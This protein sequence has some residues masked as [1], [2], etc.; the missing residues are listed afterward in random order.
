MVGKKMFFDL[1][2]GV[3]PTRP[4]CLTQ[5]LTEVFSSKSQKATKIEEHCDFSSYTV[6][7]TEHTI[8]KVN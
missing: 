7:C 5:Y 8:Q 4:N 3:L 1:G 6:T 2:L